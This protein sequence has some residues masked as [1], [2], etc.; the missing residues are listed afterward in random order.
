MMDYSGTISYIQ[1]LMEKN[2]PDGKKLVKEGFEIGKTITPH[3]GRFLREHGYNSYFDYKEECVREGKIEYITLMGLATW[4]DQKNGMRQ[5]KEMCARCGFEMN[6]FFSIF[7]MKMGLPKEMWD[8]M[9]SGTAYT[10]DSIEQYIEAMEVTDS[11]YCFSDHHLMT[12]NSLE[13]TINSI[14]AGASIVGNMAEIV[15][16]FPGF[17]DNVARFSDAVRSIGACAAHYDRHL[18]VYGYLEDGIPGFFSDCAS[19]VAFALLEKYIVTDLCGARYGVG[20]GGLLHE[21]QPRL[22]LAMALAKVLSEPEKEQRGVIWMNSTTTMQWDH[23]IDANYG[24]SAQE[25]LL[26]FL[27]EKKYNL[28]MAFMPVSVTEALQVPTVQELFNIFACAKRIEERMGDWMD[29]VDFTP[30]EKMRDVMIEKGTKMFHNMLDTFEKAGVDIHDPL[31]ILMVLKKYNPA[32][33]E[34]DFHPSIEEV[35]IFTPYYPTV[36]G[37]MTMEM[38]DEICQQIDSANMGSCMK[39]KKV[40]LCSADGHSYGLC[41]VESVMTHVGAEVING[42]LSVDP[43][44]ALEL[45]DE[46]GTRLIG[47]SVHSGQSYEYAKQ[48]AAL[49]KERNKDYYIFMGG[50]LNG[51]L[52]GDSEPSDCTDL[53]NE[54]GIHGIDDL[55]VSLQHLMNETDK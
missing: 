50:K 24:S 21:G 14:R 23:D 38:R 13:N 32:K 18:N 9:P 31:Q 42:G 6:T 11:D 5:F 33:L 28:G 35:G 34:T 55:F 48:L 3:R 30:L 7:N 10:M 16:D 53:I 54:L 43:I 22:A 15:W 19:F 51:I 17:T 41:L 47:I 25:F 44:D 36:L 37:R 29:L 26:E 45:A 46:E 4:E 40:V 27:V 8:S 1:N 49:C 39:D 2:L 52:P 20:F 12:P